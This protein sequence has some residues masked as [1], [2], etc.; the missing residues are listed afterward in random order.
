MDY[1]NDMLNF[2]EDSPSPF[3]AVANISDRLEK[4]GFTRLFEGESWNI[5]S[6]KNYFVCRNGSSVIAFKAPSDIKNT[7]INI[8]ASHCDSPVF[9]VKE[10]HNISSG[11]YAVI[12]TEIYG[13]MI[14]S[15]WF[16]RPLSAAGRIFVHSGHKI[17]QKLVNID[18]DLLIIPNLAIHMDRSIND[19]KKFNAQTDMLPLYGQG[20]D[21]DF[22]QLIAENAG[23][24]KED[25][26]GHDIFLYNRQKGTVLGAESQYVASPKLDDLQCVY[27]SFTGFIESCQS[28]EFAIL[29]IFDNEEVGSGTKQGAASGFM[30]DVISRVFSLMGGNDEDM[31]KALA[32]G[33]MISADNAHALHPNHLALADPTNRPVIN[34]GVVI[35]YNANQRYTTDGL[36]AAVFK[37]IVQSIGKNYQT[38]ANRSDMPGGST[39]GSIS[40]TRVSLNTVDIGLPQLAM[41]S[42]FET[43]GVADTIDF[44]DICRQ[45]FS[46]KI[47]RNGD[48][49]YTLSL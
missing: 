42:A 22:M 23:V 14:M 28:G 32:K 33:F 18:R 44:I 49:Q 30:H 25:I 16:D 11:P 39:L 4:A 36:S 6:G 43:A 9:K 3:H 40:N 41:H 2:I 37:E 35:K 48:E 5:N 13:G 45:F 26:A 38:F 1:I 12:N 21:K 31:Q 10:N 27:T 15:S 8:V 17:T 47:E 24:N 34:G 19:G 20:Q 46:L 7:G 29:A